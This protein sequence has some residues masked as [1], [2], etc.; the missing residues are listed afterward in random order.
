MWFLS[1]QINT[2]IYFSILI[3]TSL[4]MVWGN[5]TLT[6]SS[7]FL[8]A[9]WIFEGNY[10]QKLKRLITSP[11]ALFFLFFSFVIFFWAVFQLPHPKA[12]KDIWQNAPLFVFAF[13]MGSK[14]RINVVQMHVILIVFVLSITVNTLFNYIFFI[15]NSSEFSDV[16][17]VSLFMSY[18]R[19][20]LY[21]LM[22][23]VISIYYLF[24][25]KYVPISK[26]QRIVLW[27][28]FI[29]LLFFVLFLGSITGYVVLLTL[30]I[31]FAFSQSFKQKDPKTRIIFLLFLIGSISTAGGIFLHELRF[32]TKTEKIVVSQLDST[33]LLGNLYRP[34]EQN[35]M[36]ENGNW[37]NKYI[38][39]T[40]INKFWHLYSDIP[41]QGNDKKIQPIKST[42]IRYLTSKGLRKDAS[43]LKHL[44]EEDVINIENGCTNY[45]FVNNYH[46]SHRIYE[47]L[48]EFHYYLQ[49][50][51]PA[52]HSV[53]QRLEFI[54]CAFKVHQKNK[55]WGTGPVNFIPELHAQYPHQEIRLPQKF[56]YKPHNQF[57]SF[58]VQYGYVGFIVIMI[59]FIGIYVYAQSS[60]SILSISWFVIT[61]I[62]FL[63]EDT[64]ENINGLV[65]FA[66][67]G[68][69]LLCSQPNMRK[70]SIQ[71]HVN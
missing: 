28:C 7:Y 53:T 63:N 46:L 71:K 17:N 11:P 16:R 1:K 45:R 56:W 18:I 39:D 15:V 31:V 2:I 35:S 4:T 47:V 34:F 64:L 38:C 61:V 65:F 37:V 23:I 60:H 6:L 20:S 8:L 55:V 50:N 68:C 43:G 14:E 66:F 52:G 10:I 70:Y 32:F 33:T 19:L 51:S 40:E 54:K 59:C 67:F 48:W 9:L 25:H 36:L 41:I 42:L 5:F 22:G 69:F 58:L 13:V 21:T 57:L 26:K 27:C 29:W 3:F 49:G 62:S 44:S 12:Y 30:S 24:Y